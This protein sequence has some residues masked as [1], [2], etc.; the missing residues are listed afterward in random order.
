MNGEVSQICRIVAAARTAMKNGTEYNFTPLK[1]EGSITF[2]FCD[3]TK[4]GGAK[5]HADSPAEWY[6]HLQSEGVANIF[7]IMGLKVARQQLGYVNHS[8]TTI[9]VRYADNTVTRFS[10]Y[11]SFDNDARL[12]HIVYTEDVAEGAPASDPEYRNE[13]SLLLATLTDIRQLAEEIGEEAFAETFRKA[14]DI[15]SGDTLP[16]LKAGSV[17]PQLPNEMMK[18]YLAVDIADVFGAI[19]SWNDTGAAAA[20]SHNKTRDYVTLSERLV[21]GIRLMTMYAVNFP[22]KQI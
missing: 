1:Y 9:F 20:Q 17:P 18:Y 3:R 8:A 11:W 5:F 22:I 2:D 10:P 19:G 13:A 7:M 4:S 12:W 16:E 14:A 21:C 6:S 15:L